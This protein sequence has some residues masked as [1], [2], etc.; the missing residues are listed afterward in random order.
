[1]MALGTVDFYP[2]ASPYYGCFQPGCYDHLIDVVS[3]SHSRSHYLY[4]ASINGAA[5]LAWSVCKGDPHRIPHNCVPMTTTSHLNKTI[6][7]GNQT[8]IDGSN[9]I[10]NRKSTIPMGYWIDKSVS[11]LY[12]V[13]VT[14]TDPYCV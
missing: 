10:L 7:K 4:S 3:C 13:N 12:T 2:G 11:G 14:G 6:S 5:C 9:E 8:F 1:M